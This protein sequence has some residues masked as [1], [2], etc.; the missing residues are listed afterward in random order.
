MPSKPTGA[1]GP[2]KIE[3]GVEI[4]IRGL[5]WD[6]GWEFDC[7]VVIFEP[8]LRVHEDGCSLEYA[9]ESMLIDAC[10]D[11]TLKD[12]EAWRWEDAPGGSLGYLRRKFYRKYV[13]RTDVRVRF[14][15]DSD[16][17]LAWEGIQGDVYAIS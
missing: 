7:P 3:P 10:I 15:L 9:V 12:H 14:I 2:I 1:R 6:D 16:G 5:R 17:E 8:V 4:R 11:G 13:E